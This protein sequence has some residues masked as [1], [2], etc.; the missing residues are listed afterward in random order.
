MGEE[1]AKKGEIE[2]IQRRIKYLLSSDK[3]SDEEKVAVARKF[4]QVLEQGEYK[5][6]DEVVK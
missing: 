2:E 5:K 6:T 4:F 3:F 1:S